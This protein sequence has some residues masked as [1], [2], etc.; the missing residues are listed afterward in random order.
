MEHDLDSNG[1]TPAVES[2]AINSDTVAN[3]DIAEES[4]NDSG[5]SDSFFEFSADT[6]SVDG[7]PSTD[8]E[9][10]DRALMLFKTR[11]ELQEQKQ[12]NRRLKTKLIS[13][14]CIP[15]NQRRSLSCEYCGKEYQ[16]MSG[17]KYHREK[18][19]TRCN[20]DFV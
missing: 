20:P 17:L 18:A 2:D 12:S 11:L 3:E 1:H 16:S 8:Q 6:S 15:L 10:E 7:R 13:F 14:P 19:Q 5:I 9:D 4:L